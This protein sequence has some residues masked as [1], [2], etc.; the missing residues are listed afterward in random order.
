MVSNTYFEINIDEISHISI[1][2]FSI[3]CGDTGKRGE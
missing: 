1:W 3:I 2:N